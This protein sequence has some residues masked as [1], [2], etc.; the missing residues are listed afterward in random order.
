MLPKS[1]FSLELFSQE[2]MFSHIYLARD[3]TFPDK[4]YW[5]ALVLLFYL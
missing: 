3:A 1:N 2:N 5:F 4:F